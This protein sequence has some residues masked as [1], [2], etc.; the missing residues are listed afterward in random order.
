M[1]DLR[2][3]GKANP[4]KMSN[5]LLPMELDTAMSPSPCLATMTEA[6]VSGTEVPAARTV[7]PIMLSGMFNMYPHITP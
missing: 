1:A 7:M 4:S 3:H 2:N 5:T 6:M